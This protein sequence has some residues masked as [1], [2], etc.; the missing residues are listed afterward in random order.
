MPLR[1]SKMYFFIFGFQR[2]VWW[3]KWTP[4]SRSIFMVTTDML[5]YLLLAMG[6]PPPRRPYPP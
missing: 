4:A 5:T 1:A 2:L 3:P 6:L